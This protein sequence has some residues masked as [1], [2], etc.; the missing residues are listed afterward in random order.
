M[1]LRRPTRTL[2]T[3]VLTALP[4]MSVL[5]DRLGGAVVG[6]LTDGQ[7]PTVPEA[8]APVAHPGDPGLFGPDS[9]TWRIHSDLSMLVGGVRSLL[10]QSLHP[11]AMTGVA[12]HSAYREDPLG[13]LAR[14][15]AYVGV[16]TF[17]A[18]PEAE[19][20]VA[21]VR[22]VHST[23]RGTASDGR[24]YSADDPE[25]LAW[26][27]NVEV[28]SFLRAYRR[29][30]AEPLGDAE[31]DRYVDEMAVLLGLFGVEDPHLVPRTADD[32]QRWILTHPEQA[33]IPETTEAVRFL[34]LPPLP[35]AALAPYGVL[36]A[37]AVGLV[38]VRQ[39]RVLGLAAPVPFSSLDRLGPAGAGAGRLMGGAV[40]RVGEV[41]AGVFDAV[42]VRPAAQTLMGVMG[43]ALGPESPA[44]AAAH[45][46]TAAARPDGR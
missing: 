14:T 13:R 23:V 25:L 16:T 15:G 42:A 30:G 37:A 18:V 44:L 20:M 8:D 11:L 9:V 6:L 41:S 24:P 5:R 7:G 12:R 17:G 28:D 40:D 35:A 29:Y 10:V 1:V 36:A 21:M 45:R 31:A 27:H 26:V 38:P 32:L 19:E 43:W 33:R 4:G 39:R 46:R 3:S 34:V 22:A 2:V